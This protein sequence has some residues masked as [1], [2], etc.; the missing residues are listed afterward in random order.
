MTYTK[1]IM[2]LFKEESVIISTQLINI[3]TNSLLKVSIRWLFYEIIPHNSRNNMWCLCF[4]INFYSIIGVI[5]LFR[6]HSCAY[7]VIV[8]F[9]ITTSSNCIG[10]FSITMSSDCIGV[11]P[12]TMS[13]DCILYNN[14]L[15]LYSL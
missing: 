2:I 9:Y 12:I 14:V 6:W 4:D 3:K 5:I 15:W 7:Y 8:V 1:W 11:I 13:S 10:V